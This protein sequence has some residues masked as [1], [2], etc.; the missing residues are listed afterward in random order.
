MDRRLLQAAKVDPAD[1]V[2]IADGLCAVC[3]GWICKGQFA[4]PG[5][6]FGYQLDQAV[7]AWCYEKAS[8]AGVLR[9][10]GRCSAN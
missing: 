2:C 9:W 6:V 3:G 5:D 7:C 4:L 10:F 8:R 1:R